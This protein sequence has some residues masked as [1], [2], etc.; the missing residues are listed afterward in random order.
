M[1][2]TIREQA[3][4]RWYEA[5]LAGDPGLAEIV[6]FFDQVAGSEPI[7]KREQVPGRRSRRARGPLAVLLALVALAAAVGRIAWRLT[8]RAASAFARAEAWYADG[9]VTGPAIMPPV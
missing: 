3:V 9:V 5:S 2:L 6:R 1:S 8:C 4:L 7:P